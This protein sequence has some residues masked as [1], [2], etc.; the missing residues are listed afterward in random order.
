MAVSVPSNQSD[1][2]PK[3][4]PMVNPQDHLRANRV[5]PQSAQIVGGETRVHDGAGLVPRWLG[6]PRARRRQGRL[7]SSSIT[8]SLVVVELLSGIMDLVVLAWW[9]T[10]AIARVSTRE[11]RGLR[12]RSVRPR[13]RTPPP[14]ARSWPASGS[15]AVALDTSTDTL[16]H[17]SLK[18]KFHIRKFSKGWLVDLITTPQGR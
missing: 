15:G 4:I 10:T 2:G 18:I 17:K 1:T 5:Q 6:V 12:R 11:R 7:R 13:R 9:R 8:V 16:L 14:T 3:H